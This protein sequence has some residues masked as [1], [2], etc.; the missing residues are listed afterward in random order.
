MPNEGFNR[1]VSMIIFLCRT[2]CSCFGPYCWARFKR[3]ERYVRGVSVVKD[4]ILFTSDFEDLLVAIVGNVAHCEA[5]VVADRGNGIFW[6]GISTVQ[7]EG[8]ISDAIGS[9]SSSGQVLHMVCAGHI[10]QSHGAQDK[11]DRARLDEHFENGRK[12]IG[13]RRNAQEQGR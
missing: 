10:G 8:I 12:I 3:R 13:M 11:Q 5:A 4:V 7:G 2:R 6:L 9:L 1:I